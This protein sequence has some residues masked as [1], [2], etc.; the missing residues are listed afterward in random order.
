MGF[1]TTNQAPWLWPCIGF[2]KGHLLPAQ[3]SKVTTILIC[4]CYTWKKRVF[5]SSPTCSPTLIPTLQSWKSEVGPFFLK[6]GC[7]SMSEPQLRPQLCSPTHLSTLHCRAKHDK[8]QTDQLCPQLAQKLGTKLW[9]KLGPS[10]PS[11]KQPKVSLVY[12]CGPPFFHVAWWQ[13][14]I[15]HID[16]LDS[17]VSGRWILS[18]IFLRLLSLLESFTSWEVKGNWDVELCIHT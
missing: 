10:W 3:H 12:V 7:K 9:S 11:V 4:C 5:H 1:F 6:L 2:L 8:A 18:Q 14:Q 13:H 17:D 16:R 15:F